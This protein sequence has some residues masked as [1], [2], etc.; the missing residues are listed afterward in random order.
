MTI[1]KLDRALGR[2]LGVDIALHIGGLGGDDAF[3]LAP[4]G[5]CLPVLM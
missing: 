4:P 5:T 1:M 2:A 3:V